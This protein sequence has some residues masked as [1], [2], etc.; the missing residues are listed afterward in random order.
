MQLSWNFSWDYQT[1]IQYWACSPESR[2]IPLAETSPLRSSP[3]SEKQSN[4]YRMRDGSIFDG[5]RLWTDKIW[6]NLFFSYLHN[7]RHLG[8]PAVCPA[9]VL[10]L[11]RKHCAQWSEV[12]HQ[13][14]GTYSGQDSLHPPPSLPLWSKWKSAGRCLCSSSSSCWWTSWWSRPPGRGGG[15]V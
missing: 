13:A 15:W 4:I 9:A 11:P 3:C 7:L 6:I 12:R 1:Q 2:A 5:F 10:L 14:I 8:H